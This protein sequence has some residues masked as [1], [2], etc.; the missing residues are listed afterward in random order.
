M[1]TGTRRLPGPAASALGALSGRTP[2]SGFPD[3]AAATCRRSLSVSI[4]L[5]LGAAQAT[6][7]ASPAAASQ[8]VGGLEEVV[9]TAS[10]REQTVQDIPYNISAISS[11]QLDAAGIT[12]LAS[13]SRV[14]PGLQSPDLGARAAGVN[15]TFIIRGLNTSDVSNAFVAPNLTVPLVS[16]YIDEVPLFTNLRLTDIQRIE[17]LRGPQGTLYGSGSVGGTVRVI[18]NA[19]NTERTEFRPT[20]STAC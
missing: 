16:T 5:A 9:V 13:I 1:A 4:T 20:T 18:H 3:G 14:V 12:D 11:A 15:S 10:R 2:R 19:P 8:P 7:A 17:V 6:Q